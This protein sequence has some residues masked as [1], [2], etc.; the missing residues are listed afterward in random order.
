M[1]LWDEFSTHSKNWPAGWQNDYDWRVQEAKLNQFAQF[2]A[3]IDGVSIH[4]IHEHG[5]GPD[6]LLIVLTHGQALDSSFFALKK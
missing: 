3:E 1:G 5:K 2:K 6:P 4:F